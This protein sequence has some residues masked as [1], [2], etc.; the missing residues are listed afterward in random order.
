MSK[1]NT[2]AQALTPLSEQPKPRP[3]PLE[4]DPDEFL[5]YVNTHQR[6]DC[7]S[8]WGSRVYH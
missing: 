8:V 3:P 6:R 2:S 1:H 7:I 4:V 5:A